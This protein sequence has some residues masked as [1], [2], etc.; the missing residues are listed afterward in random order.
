MLVIFPFVGFAVELVVV[1]VFFDVV[2]FVFLVVELA[3]S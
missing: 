1:L 2:V 3:V